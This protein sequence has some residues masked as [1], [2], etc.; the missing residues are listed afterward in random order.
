M[1]ED[2]ALI[3]VLSGCNIIQGIGHTIKFLP[4]LL[5]KDMFS[6]LSD[7]ILSG[8]D[9]AFEVGIHDLDSLSGGVTL[10]LADVVRA[11]EELAVK[12]AALD[13]V[14]I[15][16]NDTALRPGPQANHSPVLQH[17][18][19]NS[20]GTDE[21]LLGVCDLVLEILTK[22]GNLAI[23]PRADR[24]AV[25]SRALDAGWQRF[26]GVEVE[27]LLEGMELSGH[28]LE[29]LLRSDTTNKGRHGVE[30]TGSLVT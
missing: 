21:E 25:L 20:A 23:V 17:L 19:T 28:G 27:P 4:E 5:V 3:H 24:L 22:N 12:V 8:L 6:I 29:N 13:R 18:A 9:V 15:G 30:V 2:T 14:H 11:E 26:K 1:E 10:H 16:N 7:G